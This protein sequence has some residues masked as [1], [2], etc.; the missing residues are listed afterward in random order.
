MEKIIREEKVD[1]I[2]LCRPLI[3]E[4]DLPNKIRDGKKI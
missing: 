3:R 4:P 2:A 1:F